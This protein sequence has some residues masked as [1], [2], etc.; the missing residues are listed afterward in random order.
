MLKNL[1]KRNE[2][3][4]II[5]VLIVLAIA[6]LIMLVVF[7]AVPALQRNS[8]N[9]GRKSDVARVGQAVSEWMSNNNGTVFTAGA[10]NANLDAAKASAGSLGQYTLTSGTN[11]TVATGVQAAISSTDNIVVVTGAKCGTSGATVA[12]TTRQVA[13]QYATET[14]GGTVGNCLDL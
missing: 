3:F 10:G 4:T 2:G 11:F 6:G 13:M 1:K 7:L 8:R 12:G 9:S 14:G 5:E